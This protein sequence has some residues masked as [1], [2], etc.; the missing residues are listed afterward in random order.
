MFTEVQLMLI[1]FYICFDLTEFSIQ[2][3]AQQFLPGL[4]KTLKCL[5]ATFQAS[6]VDKQNK[7]T[8]IYTPINIFQ[9]FANCMLFIC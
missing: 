1:D 3:Q 4:H 7:N 2:D 9:G 6:K 8:Y 5:E